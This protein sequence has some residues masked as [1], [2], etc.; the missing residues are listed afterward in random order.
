MIL[1]FMLKNKKEKK[2]KKEK[3]G[4]KE[5]RKKEK[6]ESFLKIHFPK[7]NKTNFSK[8]ISIHQMISEKE[9]VERNV[10]DKPCELEPMCPVCWNDDPKQTFYTI[11]GCNHK[12]CTTCESILRRQGIFIHRNYNAI[13]CPLCRKIEDI[14]YQQFLE[15]SWLLPPSPITLPT[16]NNEYIDFTAVINATRETARILPSSIRRREGT[17]GISSL[18]GRP[19]Q[20]CGIRTSS[21]LTNRR[22]PYHLAVYCCLRC[23]ICSTCDRTLTSRT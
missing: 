17:G 16:T 1:F 15:S 4:K 13:K 3:K 9:K 23:N 11:R 21:P 8:Y 14:P 20:R 19:C 22:C 18:A 6:I 7:Q 10:I 5:K 12:V 2:E